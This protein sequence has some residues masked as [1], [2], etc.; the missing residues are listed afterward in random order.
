MSTKALMKSVESHPVG[1]LDTRTLLKW[2]RENIHQHG[3][4]YTARELI[5]RVTG[6]ELSA[7]PLLNHLRQNARELYAV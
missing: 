3:K 4:R 2:L 7:E 5:K 1:R 6:R